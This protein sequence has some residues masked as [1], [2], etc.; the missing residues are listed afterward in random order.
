MTRE[1]ELVFGV[2]GVYLLALAYGAGRAAI[3][4]STNR[5]IIAVLIVANIL[6]CV[7]TLK[8]VIA[9]SLPILNGGAF[10]AVTIVWV[11]ALLPSYRRSRNDL[12]IA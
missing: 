11:I 1:L 3:S 9:G 12:E 6:D 10:V 7:V 4:P 5:G 2:A 8:A